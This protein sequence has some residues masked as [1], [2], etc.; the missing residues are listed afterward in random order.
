MLVSKLKPCKCKFTPCFRTGE[1]TNGSGT[2]P[3]PQDRN[4]PRKR[5]ITVAIL[6]LIHVTQATIG[7]RIVVASCAG[8]HGICLGLRCYILD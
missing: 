3:N 1:T 2:R 7:R 4:P 5:W 6:E 8:T